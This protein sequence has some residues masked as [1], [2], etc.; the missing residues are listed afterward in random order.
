MI[1]D[2]FGPPFNFT[3]IIA[4]IFFAAVIGVV[5]YF[6]F[7]SSWR[8]IQIFAFVLAAVMIIIA[9]IMYRGKSMGAGIIALFI[10]A[11]ALLLAMGI[12]IG[13]AAKFAV[14]CLKKKRGK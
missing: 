5:A 8:G 11:A 4:F 1:F 7:R 2:W 6:V 9:E 14:R 13:W 10:E 3:S 12:L